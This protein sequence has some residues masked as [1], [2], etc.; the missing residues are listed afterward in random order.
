MC[1]LLFCVFLCFLKFA[2]RFAVIRLRYSLKYVRVLFAHFG[3]FEKKVF[4]DFF[5]IVHIC[6]IVLQTEKYS[7]AN[8]YFEC[9]KT[10][11][12]VTIWLNFTN[13]PEPVRS[14]KARHLVMWY[15]WFNSEVSSAN[16]ISASIALVFIN[17]QYDIL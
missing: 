9:L 14:M 12:F 2:G 3:T 13:K 17:I 15:V 1:G 11:I 6:G 10:Y 4:C 7:S 16:H 5:V 8:S